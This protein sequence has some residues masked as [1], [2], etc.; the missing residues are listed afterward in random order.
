[1]LPTNTQDSNRSLST[2]V[3][4]QDSLAAVNA[5]RVSF[6]RKVRVIPVLHKDDYSESEISATWFR[7]TDLMRIKLEIQFTLAEIQR[8]FRLDDDDDIITCRGIEYRTRDGKELRARN[9]ADGLQA[10]LREQELQRKGNFD[11]Q[12]CIAR[13]YKN[14][15]YICQITAQAIGRADAVAVKD[16]QLA[17]VISETKLACKNRSISPIRLSGKVK[18]VS[19]AAA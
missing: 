12:D 9:K 18:L 7:P 11:D 10:V 14:A 5:K 15:T 19:T 17:E 1:M 8:G 3:K 2:V 13:E 4:R 16:I 6:Y